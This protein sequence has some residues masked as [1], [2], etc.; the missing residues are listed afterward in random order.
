MSQALRDSVPNVR[1]AAVTAIVKV[2]TSADGESLTPAP[3]RLVRQRP[4]ARDVGLGR[5]HVVDCRAESAAAFQAA[6]D[7][8]DGI[9]ALTSLAQ[10]ALPQD[11]PMFQRFIL[12]LEPRRRR[13]SVEGLARLADMASEARFKRDFQREKE[14]P[15]GRV[16]LR[17]FLAGRPAVHRHGDSGLGGSRDLAR[18]SRGYVEELGAKAL[19]E[20]LEYFTERDPK[21]RAGLVRRPRERRSHRGA[22]QHPAADQR[23]RPARRK[24][25]QPSGSHPQPAE[26]EEAWLG[27]VRPLPLASM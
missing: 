22:A 15:C 23:K 19:P 14:N 4:A 18:Q 21:I 7:S 13:A 27:D 9:L 12:Q 26:V 10:L 24:R 11:R 1:A 8:D 16:R 17:H 2:G 20:A 25:G 3:G 5:L 6:P